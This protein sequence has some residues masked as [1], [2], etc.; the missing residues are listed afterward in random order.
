MGIWPFTEQSFAVGDI[1]DVGTELDAAVFLREHIW[2]TPYEA[3]MPK[4]SVHGRYAGIGG[5]LKR[6]HCCISD[7]GSSRPL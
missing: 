6:W 1:R 7:R 5:M 2:D 3:W 4:K